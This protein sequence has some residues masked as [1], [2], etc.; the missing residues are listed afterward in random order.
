M[1]AAGFFVVFEDFGVEKL[2]VQLG[3]FGFQRGDFV[4]FNEA[5][6]IFASDWVMPL[7]PRKTV[8]KMS[9]MVMEKRK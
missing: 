3:L 9:R 5:K 7:P 4:A 1:Q 2:R 6:L 8:L